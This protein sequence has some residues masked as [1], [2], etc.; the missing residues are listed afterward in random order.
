M[1]VLKISF[2]AEFDS[3]ESRALIHSRLSMIFP[4]LSDHSNSFEKECVIITWDVQVAIITLAKKCAYLHIQ[5]LGKLKINVQCNPLPD[6]T[7]ICPMEMWRALLCL[8]HEGGKKEFIL[9]VMHA[10]KTCA[11]PV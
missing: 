6:N 3:M 9:F 2:L 7:H 8:L 10:T 1:T 4:L 11:R 5:S